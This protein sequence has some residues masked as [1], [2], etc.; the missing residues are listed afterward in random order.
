VL[1]LLRALRGVGE[2]DPDRDNTQR[3]WTEPATQAL[4]DAK[5]AV[6]KA[7]ADGATA[8]DPDLL[9]ELRERSAGLEPR[10][11]LIIADLVQMILRV[12]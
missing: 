5:A 9:A 6:A 11:V 2:L 3:C 4:L 12:G 10:L 8:L 1:H 7:G